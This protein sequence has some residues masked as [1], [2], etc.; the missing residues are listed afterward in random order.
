MTPPLLKMNLLIAGTV[1]VMAF[2]SM[3]KLL[4][5]PSTRGARLFL[6]YTHEEPTRHGLPKAP[7]V[8]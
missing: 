3:L 7:R 6:V 2:D 5:I 1:V 8:L 4:A